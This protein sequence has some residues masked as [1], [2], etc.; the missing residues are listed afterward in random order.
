MTWNIVKFQTVVLN[1]LFKLPSGMLMM[2]ASYNR[3][4]NISWTVKSTSYNSAYCI[5]F[6]TPARGTT[7]MVNIGTYMLNTLNLMEIFQILS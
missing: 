6:K 3:L 5:T 2:N 4:S 1:S 7:S